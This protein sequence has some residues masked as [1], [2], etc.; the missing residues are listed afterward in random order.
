MHKHIRTSK[1]KTLLIALLL[2]LTL[3]C[4]TPTQEEKLLK[5]SF[6]A[7]KARDWAAFR[8]NAIT[9][10]DFDM[11]SQGLSSPIRK[12]MSYS[13][14]LKEEELEELRKLFVRA[15][16]PGDGNIDFSKDAYDGF[17]ILDEAASIE[18]IAGDM[19]PTKIYGFKL[20]SKSSLATGIPLYPHLAVVE[21]GSFRQVI[22]IILPDE[23]Y[24]EDG[25]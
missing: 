8:E 25:E 1:L 18:T 4:H 19:I 21:W 5:S 7:F 23:E 20:K 9:S 12:S 2:L 11:K 15:S 24:E 22:N 16:V 13:A 10:S 3:G 6:E 17:V 14:K